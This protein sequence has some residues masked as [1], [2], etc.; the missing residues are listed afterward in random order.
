M[1]YLGG[2][3]FGVIM[4]AFASMGTGNMYITAARDDLKKYKYDNTKEFF[5]SIKQVYFI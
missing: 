5:A 1:S 4:L 2:C 3:F